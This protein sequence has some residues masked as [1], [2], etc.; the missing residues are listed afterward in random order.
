[1]SE[2]GFQTGEM[3]REDLAVLLAIYLIQR[4]PDSADKRQAAIGHL[5]EAT[6]Y[7]SGGG[8]PEVELARSAGELSGLDRSIADELLGPAL[9]TEV[10][11][12]RILRQ[13]GRLLLSDDRVEAIKTAQEQSSEDERH[14]GEHVIEAASD[15]LGRQPVQLSQPMIIQAVK[16]LV[17]ESARQN[18]QSPQDLAEGQAPTAGAFE[19]RKFLAEELKVVVDN[20]EVGQLD[21]L[22][23]AIRRYFANLDE[24]C[25]RYATGL[26]HKVYCRQLLN[27]DPHLH[28]VQR[29][30]LHQTRIYLDTNVAVDYL[31]NHADVSLTST[32]I[33]EAT[34]E[35]GVQLLISPATMGELLRLRNSSGAYSRLVEDE[36]LSLA[37][38]ANP[39]IRTN[40]FTLAFVKRRSEKHTLTWAGFMAMFEDMEHVLFAKNILVEA[41]ESEGLTE[42]S[43]Y[44]RVWTT[45]R[46]VKKD[47]LPDE[48]VTHDAANFVLIH[49]LR[50]LHAANILFGPSVWLITRD[51]TLL[52]VERRLARLY[53]IPHSRQIADWGERLLPFQSIGRFVANDYVAHI[54]QARFGILPQA[55]GLDLEFVSLLRRTQFD[56]DQVLSLEPEY[57]AQVLVS[58]QSNRETVEEVKVAVAAAD[59]TERAAAGRRLDERA[60]GLMALERQNALAEAEKVREHLVSSETVLQRL[61]EENRHARDEI[62]GLRSRVNRFES[63]SLFQ[64]IRWLFGGRNEEEPS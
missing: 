28:E 8:I 30:T 41:E 29:Q 31:L 13:N 52:E 10:E 3:E 17:I 45:V 46:E 59:P 24:P 18:L 64:R 15:E 43:E 16:T 49:R 57:A 4:S 11:T 40:P 20:F 14:F 33:L 36:R 58:M 23:Y 48:V 51:R 62:E 25:Q 44:E 7:E 56:L 19:Q 6:L 22:V 50:G 61:A 32:K 35:L 63:A 2:A 38:A 60:L 9:E 55:D 12:G 27:L 37:I 53:E 1:M 39:G 34:H 54:L 5:I 21:T 26:Y 47:Y 42:E